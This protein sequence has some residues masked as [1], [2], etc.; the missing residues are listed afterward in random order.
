MLDILRDGPFRYIHCAATGE[1]L[2]TLSKATNGNGRWTGR[3]VE[4]EGEDTPVERTMREWK[5]IV[6][7]RIGDRLIT[8]GE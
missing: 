3:W 2:L 1:L 7:R 6:R 8:D 4:F 5:A